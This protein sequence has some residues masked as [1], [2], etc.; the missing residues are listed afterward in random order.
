MTWSHAEWKGGGATWRHIRE[1]LQSRAPAHEVRITRRDDF[2][3]V[4]VAL[5]RLT[6]HVATYQDFDH[7]ALRGPIEGDLK[8]RLDL[9]ADEALKLP[10]GWRGEATS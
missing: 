7:Q 1:Y 5:I 8:R 6:D 9:I 4:L 3:T 2:V 10:F